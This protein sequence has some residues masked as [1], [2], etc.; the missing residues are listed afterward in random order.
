M[1]L[2]SGTNGKGPVFH[3]VSHPKLLQLAIKVLVIWNRFFQSTSKFCQCRQNRFPSPENSTI[4]GTMRIN[5][6]LIN[7]TFACRLKYG[8]KPSLEFNSHFS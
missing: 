6:I 8:A 2:K 3:F 4:N 7:D 5:D 1:W